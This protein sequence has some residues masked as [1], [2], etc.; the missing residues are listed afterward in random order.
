M[1]MFA[2]VCEALEPPVLRRL[3][4]WGD[5][6]TG[7]GLQVKADPRAEGRV[8]PYAG[9]TPPK[10]EAAGVKMI[11]SSLSCIGHDFV[12]PEL[13]D[14]LGTDKATFMPD[15]SRIRFRNLPTA[16]ALSQPAGPKLLARRSAGLPAATSGALR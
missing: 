1:N 14:G 11:S 5:A 8:T 3:L 2:A 16:S 10:P 7:P 9:S 15:T 4:S 12:Q 6:L 13:H